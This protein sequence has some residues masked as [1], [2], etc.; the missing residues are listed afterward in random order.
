MVMQPGEEPEE[1]SVHPH[2]PIKPVIGL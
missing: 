1:Y 2:G